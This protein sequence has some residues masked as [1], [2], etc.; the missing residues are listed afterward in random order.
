MTVPANQQ[1][2]VQ[3][4][5]TLKTQMP[6][7]AAMQIAVA[8]WDDPLCEGG[9]LTMSM[10]LAPNRNHQ[11]TAFAGSLNALCTVV[12]W[13]TMFLL[14]GERELDGNIVIHRSTIRYRRPVQRVKIVARALPL[15]TEAVDYFFELLDCKG[16][17]K[18]EVSVD[19]A[20]QKDKLVTF[21]GSYVV[22]RAESGE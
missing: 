18:L 3:L 6:I 13:G 9:R 11:E 17:S 20:D 12:G 1:L 2:L 10:P 14:M 4:E 8:N 7:S 5:Q 16:T 15:S 22:N 19:I 21:K